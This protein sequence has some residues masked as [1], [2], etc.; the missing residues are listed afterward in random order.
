MPA[1]RQA[2]ELFKLQNYSAAYEAYSQLLQ[3]DPTNAEFN[4]TVH[5]NRGIAAAKSGYLPQA[6]ARPGPGSARIAAR[7][8][9]RSLEEP[10]TC[11]CARAH[12]V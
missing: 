10:R 8:R 5:C 2:N 1:V 7:V 4:A 9:A 12:C 6:R 11:S 3:I